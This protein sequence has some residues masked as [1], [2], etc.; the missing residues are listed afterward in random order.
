MVTKYTSESF[1]FLHKTAKEFEDE[2]NEIPNHQLN[3]LTEAISLSEFSEGLTKTALVRNRYEN[4]IANN[5]TRV[6]LQGRNSEDDYINAN[7]CLD[8]RV[9]VSQGPLDEGCGG[10]DQHHE[11]FY[12][13]IFQQNVTS[14]LMLTNYIENGRIKCA[15]YLPGGNRIQDGNVREAGKYT[16]IVENDDDPKFQ[17]LRDLGFKVTKVFIS[18]QGFK[19]RT[20][21]HYHLPSWADHS[22]SSGKIA[23]AAAKI[24]LSVIQNGSNGKILVHCSA[25][26]GR[27][28]T[29]VSIVR[30]IQK[31]QGEQL[32]PTLIFDSVSEVRVSRR[33]LVQT[34][35]QYQTVFD[36]VRSYAVDD[37]KLELPPVLKP[38]P[39]QQIAN[40]DEES[41]GGEFRQICVKAKVPFPY[42]LTIRGQG[43][44]LSWERGEKLEQIDED[45]YVYQLPGASGEVEYKILLEDRDW[46]NG[47]NH[48]IDTEDRQEITPTFNFPHLPVVIDYEDNGEELYIRGNGPGMSWDKGIKLTPVNGRYVFESNEEMGD[49]EFKV[50]LNDDPDW[51][52]LGAN[53]VAE[54]GKTII[55]KPNLS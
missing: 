35:E 2:F 6:K 50:L 49:F 42:S 41:D 33:G 48:T 10:Y 12:E 29:T 11:D 1:A 14:I 3:S 52:E 30:A 51:Y 22:E 23:L 43:A 37:L 13:M 21:T 39:I 47:F 36:A 5:S 24:I 34:W 45:T 46:E 18:R 19:M 16:V 40:F 38:E 27:T 44:D 32:S 53:H 15:E 31:I 55:I 17:T 20:V 26:I 54:K 9:I 8:G 25:G 28:G 7:Y 4:I